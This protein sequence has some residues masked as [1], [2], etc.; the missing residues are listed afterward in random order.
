MA[1]T[2]YDNFVLESRLTDILNTKLPARSF[3]TIDTSLTQSPGMIK[4]IHTYTYTG[5]VEKVA[6]GATNETRGAVTFTPKDY[7]VALSQQVFDYHDEEVMQ[8]PNVVDVGMNGSATLMI[9]DLNTEFFTELGKATLEQ[10]Y[11]TALNYD[12][13]VDAVSKMNIESEEGL[14][15]IIGTD[16][17]AQLRKDEDFKKAVMSEI[18]FN[19]QIG[20]VNG[21]PV[22]V[23]KLC[24]PGEAFLATK[25]AVTCFVKKESEVEQKRQ[26]EERINTVI[27][28]KVS[29]VA[30]TDATKVVKLKK[31]T[32]A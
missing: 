23:S 13:I 30:L 21:V 28:R 24:E 5:K 15:L 31:K 29:L 26:E 7:K 11:E 1:N 27:L 8:D 12:A 17:K 19:G 25:E 9:N 32:V 16:L 18:I 2:V 14:F 20:S 22:V 10:E 3:M 6:K 4:R